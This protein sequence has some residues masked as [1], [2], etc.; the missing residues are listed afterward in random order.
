MSD[1]DYIW[2]N[3]KK[4]SLAAIIA[5]ACC[6]AIGGIFLII[7]FIPDAYSEG[8]MTALAGIFVVSSFF[9]TIDH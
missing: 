5:G 2:D 3:N 7:A 4:T 9:F 8:L 1:E 6:L